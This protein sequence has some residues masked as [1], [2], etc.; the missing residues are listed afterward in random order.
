[1]AAEKIGVL[2]AGLMG[3][4]IA[5]V[6]ALAGHEVLLGDTSEAILAAASQRLDG[7]LVKGI[8]RG[9]YRA[10]ERPVALSR[11]VGTTELADFA[12]RDLVI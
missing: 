11:I 6:Y 7:I 5:L 3:A 2:G 1:M 4:E 8:G 10:E 12:D 9:F